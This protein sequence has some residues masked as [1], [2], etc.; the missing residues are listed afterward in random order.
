MP[1]TLFTIEGRDRGVAELLETSRRKVSELNKEIKKTNE[2]TEEFARLSRQI[3]ETKNQVSLLSAEERK[4][5]RELNAAKFPKDSLVQM[6]LEYSKLQEAISK[7]SAAERNSDIG[8]RTIKNAAAL[9]REIKKVE[10]AT[11]RFTSSVGNYKKALNTV[12]DIATGVF[13]GGG[14]YAAL[15]RVT[16]SVKDAIGGVK[17][18]SAALKELQAITGVSD[19]V[20]KDFEE[21]AN[22]ITTIYLD[23]GEKIVNT[24]ADIFNAMKLVGSAAPSLLQN[25][26]ALQEVTKNAIILSK[27]SGDDL[28]TSVNAVT[29]IM[30]QFN[31]TAEQSGEIINTLAA[32]S[33]LGAE[34]VP[35]LS[36][37][38]RI[39][40]VA[41]GGANVNLSESVA[42]VETL[43]E[44]QLRG[45]MA[46][47]QLRNVLIKLSSID[48]LPPRALEALKEGGVSLEILADRSLSLED[49]LRELGKI[50]DD[51]GKIA[52][53]FG[54]ENVNAASIL[55]QNIDTYARLTKEV[56]GTNT[57]FEQASTNAGSL[58]SKFENF[59][60]ET[61]NQLIDTMRSLQ[62]E[63]ETLLDLAGTGV[64]LGVSLLSV[65][66]KIPG[67]LKDNKEE[68]IALAV[69]YAAWN[70][71][72]IFAAAASLKSTLAFNLLTSAQAR[73]TLATELLSAAQKA[74]PILAIV[75][76]VYALVKAFESFSEGLSAT[77]KAAHAVAEAQ[78]EIAEN[79]RDEVS[80]IRENIA[81]LTDLNIATEKRQE[82]IQKLT[83]LYPE[84]LKGI[85]LELQNKYQLANIEKD[86]IELTIR[87]AAETAKSNA[88][89]EI[90]AKI[91]KAELRLAQLRKDEAEGV[92]TLQDRPFIIRGVEIGLE[93]LRKQLDETRKKFDETFKLDQEFTGSVL[94]I[95]DPRGEKKAIDLHKATI[96]EL[97]AMDDEAANEEIERREKLDQDKKDRNKKAQKAEKEFILGSIGFL[98]QQIEKLRKELE[99]APPDQVAKIIGD[100]AEKEHELDVLEQKIKDLQ[101]EAS[102]GIKLHLEIESGGT[103]V[104]PQISSGPQRKKDTS[105]QEELKSLEQVELE[106]QRLA[107]KTAK[108]RAEAEKEAF[109]KAKENAD[110]FIQQQKEDAELAIEI[111]AEKWEQIKNLAISAID[112]ISSAIFDIQRE[113]IEQESKQAL[114]AIDIEYSTKIKKAQGNDKLIEKLE[115]E[116]EQKKE[117][118]EK[119]AAEKRKKIAITESIIQTALAVVKALP[120]Y[121]LAAAVAIAGLAQTAII[122]SKQ[123]AEGGFTM[124]KGNEAKQMSRSLS[125]MVD[126]FAVGGFTGP[127]IAPADSTGQRPA[128]SYRKPWGN[129]I[130]HENEWI[131]SEPIVKKYKPLILQMEAEQRSY[132]SM[133]F[134]D[135]GFTDGSVHPA[136]SRSP[137][138]EF[139]ERSAISQQ[140]ALASIPFAS[141]GFTALDLADAQSKSAERVIVETQISPELIQIM[142]QMIGDRVASATGAQVRD[143]MAKGLGDS[144]RR[145]E[146]ENALKNSRSI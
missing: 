52:R 128:G 50:Q 141:G 63:I 136:G 146:R 60:Q 66:V 95:V 90:S 129:V 40:G 145:L 116:K 55:L 144:N 15:T 91:V 32:G 102:K 75:G 127:G 73:A 3:S 44:R 10:E 25:A 104:A 38:I 65:L 21:R 140:M 84:Y 124:E 51:T 6:R 62:P 108:T 29:T 7:M 125:A 20:L 26:A 81:V 59:A 24:S 11:G 19:E 37:A 101:A 121:F 64:E 139:S 131:A 122:A 87:K 114:K 4:L 110:R 69:A 36:D 27:A 14:I 113:R 72:A 46:G 68:M 137:Y 71:E 111:D 88:T 77:A 56:Q 83:S 13:L 79:S 118:I 39:F 105:A 45:A 42:L 134:A 33:K 28:E 49:R 133:P 135:G 57:A 1:T 96:S 31:L 76:G 18:Y 112:S 138:Q 86:L 103:P 35:G 30:G 120:N 70:K 16:Q 107:K 93:N 78:S 22:S 126:N 53:V 12:G 47:T 142:G 80:A 106:K 9:S 130:Y 89:S 34:A 82:A 48:A 85:N 61:Q 5:N 132:A 143:A 94:T 58:A 17:E 2:G 92:F 123:F 99:G 23:G 8:K 98:K 117:K 41:A 74:I 100:L 115:K 54:L 67:F 119:E 109:A 43:A 97:K